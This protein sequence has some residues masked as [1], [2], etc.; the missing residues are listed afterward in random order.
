MSFIQRALTDEEL[1]K[2]QKSELSNDLF[3]FNLQQRTLLATGENTPS[4]Q[5]SLTKSSG[6]SKD[7]VC[8]QCS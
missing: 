2:L 1:S 8:E 5:T 3:R 4:N 6:H 7:C